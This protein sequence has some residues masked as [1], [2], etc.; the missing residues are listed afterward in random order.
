MSEEPF[1]DI[2]KWQERISE[3][4]RSTQTST[5]S[6][7]KAGDPLLGQRAVAALRWVESNSAEIAR[8]APEFL[9]RG[10]GELQM[11]DRVVFALYAMFSRCPPDHLNTN[12]PVS[13][14]L[15]RL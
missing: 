13:L 15:A 8:S 3:L 2:P 14:L 7:N 6:T 11:E 4:L 5:A 10:D 9:I 12:F 1:D